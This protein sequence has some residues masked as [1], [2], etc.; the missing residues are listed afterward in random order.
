MDQLAHMLLRG[1]VKT[2]SCSLDLATWG[3]IGGDDK[4][5]VTGGVGIKTLLEW[6]Q[7]EQKIFER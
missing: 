3:V 7:R 6:V 2:E 5:C 1:Q 4:S